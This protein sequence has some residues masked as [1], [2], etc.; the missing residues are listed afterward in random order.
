M[1]SR[2]IKKKGILAKF[3]EQGLRILLIKEC[4]KINNLKI[5]IVSSSTQI[6]KGEIQRVNINAVGI[7]Y[8][9]LLFDKVELNSNHLKINY[10]LMQRKLYFKQDPVIEFK[11]SLSQNSLRNILLSNNWNWIGN[12]ISKQILNLEKLE[13]IKISDGKFTIKASDKN[14]TINEEEQIN[15]KTE[16]GKIYLHKKNHN[17]TVQVPI[18]DKIYIKNINIE[19][20]LIIIFAKSSINFQ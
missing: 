19:N 5:N 8:K 11:I 17:K 18:E 7:D 3:L 12:I 4:K 15:I 6:I 20:N 2:L 14:N 13:D 10:N 1:I 9:G 16:K